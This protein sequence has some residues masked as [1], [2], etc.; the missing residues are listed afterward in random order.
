MRTLLG[1]RA[2]ILV[3]GQNVVPKKMLDNG[4]N[5]KFRQAEDAIED[6]LGKK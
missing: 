5:F 3:E 4:Y 6:L 2:V 1:E